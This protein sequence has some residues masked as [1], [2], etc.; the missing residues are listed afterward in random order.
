VAPLRGTTDPEEGDLPQRWQGILGEVVAVAGITRLAHRD[1][2]GQPDEAAGRV[3]HEERERQLDDGRGGDAEPHV[4]RARVQHDVEP[5]VTAQQRAGDDQAGD[6]DL[7]AAPERPAGRGERGELDEIEPDP[8]ALPVLGVER[9]V[10]GEAEHDDPADQHG[11]RNDRREDPKA[12]AS[13]QVD[14][15]HGVRVVDGGERVR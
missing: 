5:R 7:A 15:Q 6:D 1:H 11:A 2:G 4:G 13:R 14:P 12:T 10:Q 8:G 9:T 3:E